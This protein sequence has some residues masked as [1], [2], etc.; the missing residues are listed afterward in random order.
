M[1]TIR[2]RLARAV[3]ESVEILLCNENELFDQGCFNVE[4]QDYSVEAILVSD[5]PLEVEDYDGF[6][7]EYNECGFDSQEALSDYIQLARDYYGECTRDDNKISILTIFK[8]NIVQLLY[9]V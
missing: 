4:T 3:K 1:Q 6:A 9:E 8:G 7:Y 2:E 5:D